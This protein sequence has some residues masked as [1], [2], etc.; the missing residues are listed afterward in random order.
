MRMRREGDCQLTHN[1]ATCD[2]VNT[3]T[4]TILRV[5]TLVYLHPHIVQRQR[6]HSKLIH[7]SFDNVQMPSP[8]CQVDSAP[9]FL[10]WAKEALP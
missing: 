3:L 1:T 8:G 9:T 5:L 10:I 7:K 2:H 6:V 4:H